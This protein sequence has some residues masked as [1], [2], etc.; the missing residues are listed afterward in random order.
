MGEKSVKRLQRCDL[1]RHSCDQKELAG[2]QV[3]PPVI[4]YLS[5]GDNFLPKK[6]SLW[7]KHP[8]QRA[9][10]PDHKHPG[11]HVSL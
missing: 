3:A 7:Q 1:K 2:N 8:G 9:G 4:G 6:N 5:H 10:E 11:T